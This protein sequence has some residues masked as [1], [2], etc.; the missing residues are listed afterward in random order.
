M[1]RFFVNKNDIGS[2]IIMLTGENAHHIANVLRLGVGDK[3]VICDGEE[4]DYRCKISK[5]TKNNS[6]YEVWADIEEKNESL[7][8]PDTKI[9]LFQGL[10][11][12]DK[13]E[14]IIQKAVELGVHE[15]VPVITDTSVVRWEKKSVAK[16]ERF[17]KIAEA[18]AKQCGRG[19]IP[20][21]GNIVGLEEA[22]LQSKALDKSIVAYEN[23]KNF[24]IKAFLKEFNDTNLGI[25]IGP[26]GGFSESEIIKLSGAGIKSVTLGKRI[27]KTETAGIMALAVIL[28]E[29]EA[30]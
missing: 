20:K 19:R 7:A 12:A 9:T 29:L 18:A 22:V 28:Y 26:E 14:L 10:P 16:V 11:K 5:I 13:M 8:E 1:P 23:E 27:L 3:I 6:Q 4:T 15:I 24:T 25:F 30:E 17:R 2:D 21:I